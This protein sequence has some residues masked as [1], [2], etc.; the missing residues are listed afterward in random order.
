MVW[1]RGEGKKMVQ[2]EVG[3]WSEGGRRRRRKEIVLERR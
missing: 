2:R 3:W 1:R